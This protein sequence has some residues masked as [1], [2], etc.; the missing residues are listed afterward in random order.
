MYT[1]TYMRVRRDHAPLAVRGGCVVVWLRLLV[2]R[3][4]RH[5]KKK[6]RRNNSTRTTGARTPQPTK[7]ER[8]RKTAA[9]HTRPPVVFFAL[10]VVSHT[11]GSWRA[12]I[13][14]R[15]CHDDSHHSRAGVSGS[16]VHMMIIIGEILQGRQL[17]QAAAAFACFSLIK[18]FS[19]SHGVNAFFSLSPSAGAAATNL[20][21]QFA[22]RIR[23]RSTLIRS[24]TPPQ[25]AKTPS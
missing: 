7:N 18:L 12:P 3:R 19:T 6:T 10:G 20:G 23:E 9:A 8:G 24:S 17:Q 4:A 13:R 16:C 2:L 21:D 25:Q 11:R 14:E 1:H 22:E 5:R 15:L